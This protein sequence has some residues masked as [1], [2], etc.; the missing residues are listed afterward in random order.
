MSI[1]F[2]PIEINGMM[3]ANR[4]VR[5][6]TNDRRADVAGRITDEFISS[7]EALAKGG[8]GL[9]VTGHAYVTPNGKGSPTMLGVYDD[10]LIPDLKRLVDTIHKYDSRIVMQ[11]NHA[12]RQTAFSTIG[13][14][15]VAP[16]VSYNPMTHETSRAL[17]WRKK[18]RI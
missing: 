13:E 1:L 14:T 4:F 17:R 8:V 11:I 12:G 10:S 2:E 7:Y 16:S 15:P 18:S 5:S 9:I 3:V 6:A